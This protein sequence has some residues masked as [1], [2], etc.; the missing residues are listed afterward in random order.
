MFDLIQNLGA[1]MVQ[2]GQ[3]DRVHVMSVGSRVL[4][5]AE[6]Q[7]ERLVIDRGH[8]PPSW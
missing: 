2:C 6:E 3:G 8:V 5:A 7:H 1:N 4:N